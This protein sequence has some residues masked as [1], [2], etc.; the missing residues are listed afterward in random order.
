MAD[1]LVVATGIQ[2]LIEPQWLN[3][4]QIIIDVGIHRLPNGKI[5]G[6]MNFDEVFERVAWLTP[7]PGGVGPMTIISLLQN[8]LLAQ[9]VD[10]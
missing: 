4:N 6:D 7:V 8:T 10:D 1:I 2:D 5:R 9:K 3:S